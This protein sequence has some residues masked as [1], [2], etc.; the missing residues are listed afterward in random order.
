MME[1]TDFSI[2]ENITFFL[3]KKGRKDLQFEMDVN[4][5][6]RVVF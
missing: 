2:R 1:W 6:N 4:H 3:K 5:N